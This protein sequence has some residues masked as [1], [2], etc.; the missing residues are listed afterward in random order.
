MLLGPVVGRE[1]TD[2]APF[3]WK[4]TQSEPQHAGDYLKWLS[5]H[6]PL[7]KGMPWPLD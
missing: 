7:P 6:A 1:A 4:D 2:G 5:K 3:K